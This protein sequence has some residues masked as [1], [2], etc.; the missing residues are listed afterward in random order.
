MTTILGQYL[1]L[2]DLLDYVP[3]EAQLGL[4][5]LLTLLPPPPPTR[6]PPSLPPQ[7]AGHRSERNRRPRR[8]I[9]DGQKQE[10]RF[11][12]NPAQQLAQAALV[13]ASEIQRPQ[14][15]PEALH[16][17]LANLT[18]SLRTINLNQ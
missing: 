13:V 10:D 2:Q 18:L 14:Q 8:H 6:P 9:P 12:F 5:Y 17:S 3:R 7:P 16:N 15:D 4:R 11:H 1:S